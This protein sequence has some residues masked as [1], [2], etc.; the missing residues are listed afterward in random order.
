MTCQPV[1]RTRC[2]IAQGHVLRIPLT[3]APF[4]VAVLKS[5]DTGHLASDSSGG[6]IREFVLLAA[7]SNELAGMCLAAAIIY[8]LPPQHFGDD[9]NE[10][11]SAQAAA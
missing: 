8:K 4:G 3:S 10:H 1:S 9:K 2:R 7:L 5:R 6:R 11:G